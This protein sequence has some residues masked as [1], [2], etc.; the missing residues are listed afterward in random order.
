MLAILTTLPNSF[1]ARCPQ[2]GRLATAGLPL[3]GAVRM[4]NSR[5]NFVRLA[6]QRTKRTIKD[7]RLI[8]NLSNRSNYTWNDEDVKRIFSAIEAEVKIAKQRF[9]DLRNF[10]R[11]INFSLDD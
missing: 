11:D 9:E 6:E 2:V 7:V 8:G 1:L 3:N 5:E 4:S 10:D